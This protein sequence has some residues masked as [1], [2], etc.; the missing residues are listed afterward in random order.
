MDARSI[1]QQGLPGPI[2]RIISHKHG[3]VSTYSGAFP[4]TMT[5]SSSLDEI[6]AGIIDVLMTSAIMKYAQYGIFR[7]DIME[8]ER[9]ENPYKRSIADRLE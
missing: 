2:L 4:S 8:N 1:C 9:L 5:T 6:F 3:K 7:P